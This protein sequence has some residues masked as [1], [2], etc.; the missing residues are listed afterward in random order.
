MTTQLEL[1][2]LVDEAARHHH[3]PLYSEIVHRAHKQ[4]LAGASVFRGIEGFGR[5]HHLHESRAIDVDPHLPVVVVIVDDEPR[6]REFAAELR[7]LIG[8]TGVITVRPVETLQ[9]GRR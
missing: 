2:V 5:S 7:A 8:E 6:I 4:G 9:I 3:L 1:R